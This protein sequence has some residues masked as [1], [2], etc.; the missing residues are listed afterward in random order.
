MGKGPGHVE[1]AI[2][3]VLIAE[4]D[5]AFTIEDLCERVF[6][7]VNRIEGNTGFM[8]G[9]SEKEKSVRRIIAGNDFAK[10]ENGAVR[11]PLHKWTNR[12]TV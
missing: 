9:V 3:S 6:R 4:P 7:G 1:R 10:R 11:R 2:E 12:E 8:I 5:N